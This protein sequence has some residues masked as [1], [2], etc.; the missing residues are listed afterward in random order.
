MFLKMFVLAA[1]ML[2]C[3]FCHSGDAAQCTVTSRNINLNITC[4]TGCCFGS[5]GFRCCGDTTTT[6]NNNDRGDTTARGYSGVAAPH[7]S[8][9]QLIV[10]ACAAMLAVP[11]VQR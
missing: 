6:T 9:L 4:I 5:S 2:F 7:M 10:F 11:R 8:T 1:M 3:L